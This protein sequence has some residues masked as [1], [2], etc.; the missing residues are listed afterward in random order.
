MLEMHREFSDQIRD[1]LFY[2]WDRISQRLIVST[3]NL[4]TENLSHTKNYFVSNFNDIIVRKYEQTSR[5]PVLLT[6]G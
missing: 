3:S 4:D 5:D 2:Y 6:G 1:K